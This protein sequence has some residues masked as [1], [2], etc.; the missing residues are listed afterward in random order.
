MPT[1]VA[2]RTRPSNPTSAKKSGLN[3]LPSRSPTFGFRQ[4][5]S[6]YKLPL[7]SIDTRQRVT[8]SRGAVDRLPTVAIVKKLSLDFLAPSTLRGRSTR[9]GAGDS[10]VEKTR[11]GP[12]GRGM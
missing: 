4:N 8:V 6:V 9:D 12:R 5:F 2:R 10:P 1:V 11:A 3:F 7:Y